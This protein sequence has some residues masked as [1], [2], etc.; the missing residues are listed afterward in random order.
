MKMKFWDKE[1]KQMMG[2]DLDTEQYRIISYDGFA[3][4]DDAREDEDGW[5][6][7][8]DVE[9][10][11]YTQVDETG[12]GREIYEGDIVDYDD[13]AMMP[14]LDQIYRIH[15]MRGVVEMS[16]GCWW[17]TDDS[18]Q[19]SVRLWSETAEVRIV[20]NIYDDPDLLQA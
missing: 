12:T 11:R 18:K 16:E 2:P 17:I 19:Q 14:A 1:E 4:I 6:Y 20:G 7:Q 5:P 13:S 10:L 3:L 9:F 8:M 15:Q